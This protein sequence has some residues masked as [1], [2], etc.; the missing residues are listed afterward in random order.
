MIK[1][2]TCLERI[3]RISQVYSIWPFYKEGETVD[4]KNVS[5]FARICIA[6]DNRRE[7]D[8]VTKEIFNSIDAKDI[9][10]ED[11]CYR[12]IMMED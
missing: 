2:Q 1:D 9:N 7:I 4:N 8:R 6:A 12:A 10:G 11:V 3:G 5:H